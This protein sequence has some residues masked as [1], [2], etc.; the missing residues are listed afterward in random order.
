MCSHG[1]AADVPWQEGKDLMEVGTGGP[2]SGPRGG[3][4]LTQEAVFGHLSRFIHRMDETD[5]QPSEKLASPWVGGRVRRRDGDGLRKSVRTKLCLGGV[6]SSHIHPAPH[7]H[8]T[9]EY[10]STDGHG[11]TRWGC[12]RG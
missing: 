4:Q 8:Q 11:V 1:A 2:G 10:L 6:I 7:P 5:P 3:K 12:L 9:R